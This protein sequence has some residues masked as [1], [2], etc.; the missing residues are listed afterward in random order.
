M[1]P[2]Y[3]QSVQSFYVGGTAREVQSALFGADTLISG[4]MYVQHWVPA[5]R[6]FHLPVIFI[7]G[8]MHTGVTWETC[9]VEP[10][11]TCPGL[12]HPGIAHVPVR[13]MWGDNL[14]AQAR[15]LSLVDVAQAQEV[16]A[17]RPTVT[18]DVLPENG[19]SGNGHM[20]MMENNNAALAARVMDWFVALQLA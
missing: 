8:G 19:I 13:I 7:H 17:T 14:P 12:D 6:R 16:A 2:L 5:R 4:A 10:A 20:L 9:S 15:T 11:L 1:E 3:L 18:V